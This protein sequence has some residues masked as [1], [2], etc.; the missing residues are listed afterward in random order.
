MRAIYVDKIIPRMLAVKVLRPLWPGVVWSAISPARVADLAE[1]PLPGPKWLRVRNRQCGICASDLSLLNVEVAPSVAPAA[2]PGNT[3]F[4]LGHEVVGEV[5][6]IGP[7]VDRFSIGQSVIMETR[8]LGPNCHTRASWVPIVIHSKSS[9]RA[10]SVHR[11][12]IAYAKT[13]RSGRAL[14]E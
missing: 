12:S 8:F 2:L 11:D 6:E 3:R 4:F 1:P 14:S 5:I 9:P 7:A 13:P 10:I